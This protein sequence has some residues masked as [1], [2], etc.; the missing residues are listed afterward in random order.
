MS[1]STRDGRAFVVGIS[2]ADDERVYEVIAMAD[3]SQ[4]KVPA[5]SVLIDAEPGAKDTP[6][7]FARVHPTMPVTCQSSTQWFRSSPR[8][9]WNDRLSMYAAVLIAALP[10]STC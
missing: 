4:A 1:G 2:G 8:V 7:V 10:R 9:G 6:D 3:G 5:D